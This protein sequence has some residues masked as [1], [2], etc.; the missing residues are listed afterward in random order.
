MIPGLLYIA[1]KIPGVAPMDQRAGLLHALGRIPGVTPAKD[2]GIARLRDHLADECGDADI[3][4]I[5]KT[6]GGWELEPLDIVG[7]GD[8]LWA[9][10]RDSDEPAYPAD[11]L[12][13]EPQTLLG[14][15]IALGYKNFG[16]ATEIPQF[17]R[18]TEADATVPD[19]VP[20]G[21]TASA[22]VTDV[23][24]EDLTGNLHDSDPA[25][26]PATAGQGDSDGSAGAGAAPAD[27]RSVVDRL[28]DT[29]EWVAG[30]PGRRYRGL[31]AWLGRRR[32]AHKRLRYRCGWYWTRAGATTLIIQ[33]DG[34]AMWNVEPA[35]YHKPNSDEAIWNGYMTDSGLRF[36]AREHGGEPTPVFGNVSLGMAFGPTVK[37]LAP[38][39]CRLGRNLHNVRLRRRPVPGVTEGDATATAEAVGEM[40]INLDGDGDGGDQSADNGATPAADGGLVYQDAIAI[41]E[42]ALVAPRD[43]KQHDNED[44][45]Q[46]YVQR[47][48]EQSK[49]LANPPGGNLG[50][51]A[52]KTGIVLVA[53]IIGA[54]VGD[55]GM[56]LQLWHGLTGSL[57][58]GVAL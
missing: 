57:A 58:V 56:F 50:E 39:V 45:T 8:N 2:R 31:R 10:P 36:D 38:S 9:I 33:Q 11:G 40:Q 30:W 1:G 13:E 26:N 43:I 23:L 4:G 51:K 55:P 19:P 41:E 7:E 48:V 29:A 3:L 35:D 42:R 47:A 14:T 32:D 20:G 21:P 44:A 5:I 54:L 12:P 49:A 18:D 24:D 17:D 15:P 46:E 16:A 25:V 27:A 52:L 53:A 34:D 37:L 6:D 22:G 28:R